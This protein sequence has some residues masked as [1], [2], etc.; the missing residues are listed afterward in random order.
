MGNMTADAFRDANMEW[1][2]AMEEQLKLIDED[3]ANWPGVRIAWSPSNNIER[4]YT[5][6]SSANVEYGES[7][8]V[9]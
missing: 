7:D 8:T 1:L 4:M 3:E 6:V 2:L 9:E 5:E